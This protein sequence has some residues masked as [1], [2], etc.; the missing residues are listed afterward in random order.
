MRDE[1]EPIFTL[2]QTGLGLFTLYSGAAQAGVFFN[3]CCCCWIK[4]SNSGYHRKTR[5]SCEVRRL[6]QQCPPSAA[7]GLQR[8]WAA[9]GAGPCAIL[10]RGGWLGSMATGDVQNVKV[11]ERGAQ[12]VCCM[13]CPLLLVLA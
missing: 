12:A 8:L 6:L 13:L 11:W 9:A 3:I 2:S 4:N 1:A 10:Q 5:R 7:G